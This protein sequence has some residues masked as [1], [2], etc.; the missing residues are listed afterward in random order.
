[1]YSG[2]IIHSLD[3]CVRSSFIFEYR[4]TVKAAVNTMVLCPQHPGLIFL[5]DYFS[6]QG[7]FADFSKFPSGGTTSPAS[8]AGGSSSGD[9]LDV[10]GA[11][12]GLTAQPVNSSPMQPMGAQTLSSQPMGMQ[13]MGMM[14]MGTQQPM[15]M[16]PMGAQPMTPQGMGSQQMGAQPMGAQPM[17]TQSMGMQSGAQPMGMQG[18]GQSMNMMGMTPMQPTQMG[19]QPVSTIWQCHSTSLNFTNLI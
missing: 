4:P 19:M 9:L 8:T 12:P 16:S 13:P 2:K 14:P 6:R 1:M 7:N 17:G 5:C 11:S 3:N 18:S 10:F 15:G